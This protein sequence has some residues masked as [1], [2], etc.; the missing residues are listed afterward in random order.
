MHEDRSLAAVEFRKDRRE[1]LVAK[2]LLAVAG[3]DADAV[4]LEHVKSVFDFLQR[5][6]HV[7]WGNQR[8]EADA[9]GMILREARGLFIPQS[10]N[11]PRGVDIAVPRARTGS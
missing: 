4:G 8:K 5:P 2:I 6:V 1:C 10:R 3:V 9:A 7:G 11:L